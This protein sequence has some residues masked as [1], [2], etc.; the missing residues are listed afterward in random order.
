[1]NGAG[2]ARAA[3]ELRRLPHI[4]DGRACR[5][6]REYGSATAALAHRGAD[7]VGIV[8]EAAAREAVGA[9]P[10][11]EWAESQ[12]AA[13]R[14]AGVEIA[15]FASEQYPAPVAEL[16]PPPAVLYIAGRLG[17][18]CIAM[19]GTRRCSES[20]RRLARRMAAELAAAGICVVSGM[21][22]GIDAAAH[23]GALEAGGATAAVLGSGLDRPSPAGNRTLYKRILEKGAAVAEQPM[24]TPASAGTFPKRNRIVSALCTAV[25]VAEAPARSGALITA[26]IARDLGRPLFAVPGDVAAGK[27]SGCHG[28]IRR[29][30]AGLVERA[31]DVLES[32]GLAAP[33]RPQPQPRL[34]AADDGS[35]EGMV[36]ALLDETRHVDELSEL[37][38]LGPARTLD[39][40]LRMEMSGRVVQLPGKR[41]CRP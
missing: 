35:P 2:E 15:P 6:I 27:S 8:G 30:E 21:A 17:D 28:L 25:I 13:A 22:D 9:T 41:F 10:D 5:L 20:G 16:R 32:L 33:P 23:E 29:G 19:V 7:W 1:M 34:P 39:L 11:R 26:R 37:T 12:I 4:G 36:A 14:A 38:G 3:L 40:L 18:R 31:A 24:G